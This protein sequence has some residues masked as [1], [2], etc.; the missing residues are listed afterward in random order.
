MLVA[1][2]ARLAALTPAEPIEPAERPL[3]TIVSEPQESL[4]HEVSLVVDAAGR[5]VGL[6]RR[7]TLSETAAAATDFLNGRVALASRE[8]VLLSCPGCDPETG[9]RVVLEYLSNG[10]TRRYDSCSFRLEKKEGAFQLTSDDGRP[11]RRLR[12]TA[13]RMLG[14]L[15]GIGRV[16]TE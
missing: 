9:G 5:I 14:V 6:V 1:P 15:V 13:R 10:L 2:L 7:S 16:V 8:S 11:I 3:V 4:E 12:L